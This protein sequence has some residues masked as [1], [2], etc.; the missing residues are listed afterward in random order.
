VAA[1]HGRTAAEPTTWEPALRSPRSTR[2][3]EQVLSA[4]ATVSEARKVLATECPDVTRAAAL[5]LPTISPPR[6]DHV[7]L[8]PRRRRNPP[9]MPPAADTPSE[10]GRCTTVTKKPARCQFLA[11]PAPTAAC[12][13]ATSGADQPRRRHDR[14]RR[15]RLALLERVRELAELDRPS[16]RCPNSGDPTNRLRSPSWRRGPPPR[17]IGATA[18]TQISEDV[19]VGTMGRGAGLHVYVRGS[20][21]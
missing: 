4:T 17:Q 15:R 16:G 3:A 11:E 6:S 20:D 5:R 14:A 19:G 10:P 21:G 1:A 13:T 7:R 18:M 8:L 2:A 9:T 12:F